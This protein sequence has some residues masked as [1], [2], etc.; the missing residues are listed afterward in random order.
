MNISQYIKQHPELRRLDF[1]TV[2]DTI[3]AL[4]N[5]GKLEWVIED[6]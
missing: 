6:V 3:V 2:Y 4:I 5:D 1:I